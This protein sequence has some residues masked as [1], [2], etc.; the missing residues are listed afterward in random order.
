MSIEQYSNEVIVV[1]VTDGPSDFKGWLC[2]TA[3]MEL[4]AEDRDCSWRFCDC[5]NAGSPVEFTE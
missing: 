2:E 3:I 5:R 4:S 1:A